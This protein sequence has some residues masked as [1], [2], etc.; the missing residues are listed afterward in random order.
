MQEDDDRPKQDD[1]APGGGIKIGRKLG[2][3]N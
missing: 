1:N 3:K 2:A